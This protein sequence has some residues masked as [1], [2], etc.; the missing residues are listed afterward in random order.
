MKETVIG[1]KFGDRV[2]HPRRPE[3]GT[4]SVTAVEHQ[5]LN[6]SMAQRVS[7]RFSNGGLKTI[8]TAHVELERVEQ[9][10]VSERVADQH[11]D[12]TSMQ[13]IEIMAN[14][15]WLSGVAE[16]KLS[17]RM[18]ELPMAVRDPFD[19]VRCRLQLTLDLY[20][21][22]TS[23][24]GLM[25]WAI[26]QSGLDDPLSK[27]GR[28]ELEQFFQRWQAARDDHLRSLMGDA[29]QQLIAELLES[30]PQQAR[31]AVRRITNGR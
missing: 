11:P 4:G 14:S 10:D 7:V 20:R 6:G 27:F 13:D 2:R 3:W 23:G 9:T 21:F 25:D 28:H 22:D 29:D 5:Q 26:G 16:Q 18:I 1:F 30:S 8:S 19:S 15:G 17:E 31:Q 12:Q 24:R